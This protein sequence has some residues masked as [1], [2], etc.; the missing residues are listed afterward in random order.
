[1]KTFTFK[2]KLARDSYLDN[3]ESGYICETGFDSDIGWF[4]TAILNGLDDISVSRRRVS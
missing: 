1:M 3:N 2:A 4:V